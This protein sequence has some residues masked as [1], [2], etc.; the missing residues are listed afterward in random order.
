MRP[1]L[2]FSTKRFNVGGHALAGPSC[3]IA[4]DS[5]Q[6][7]GTNGKNVL[8]LLFFMNNEFLRPLLI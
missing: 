7:T 6:Q 8:K 3:A 4:L 5:K 2:H 1:G